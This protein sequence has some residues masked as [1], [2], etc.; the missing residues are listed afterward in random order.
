MAEEDLKRVGS[1]KDAVALPRSPLGKPAFLMRLMQQLYVDWPEATSYP[2]S[3]L[4]VAGER[5]GLRRGRAG[6]F[7]G[8]P[9]E[10]RNGRPCCSA[11]AER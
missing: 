6:D 5:K 4:G 9:R 11:V 3:G 8:G 7:D 2:G 10:R 1:P